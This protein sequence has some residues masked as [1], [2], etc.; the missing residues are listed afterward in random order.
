VTSTREEIHALIQ[1]RYEGCLVRPSYVLLLGDAEF[2]D[3][4]YFDTNYSSST[5]SDF[6]Y[7]NISGGL[8]D[9]LPDMGLGRIPADTLEQAEAAVSKV[10]GYEQAPPLISSF[11]A[12]A[13]IASQFQCCRSG[14]AAGTD[15]RAF[16]EESRRA[17]ITLDAAGK[18]TEEIYTR[19]GAG[20]PA[21]FFDGTLLPPD[22]ASPYPWSGSTQDIVDA[23]NSGRFLIAHR[24]HGWEEGW[25]NPQFGSD[26]V[27]ASL[28]NGNLT[29]VVYSVNCA[30][31][32]F[33]NELAGDDRGLPFGESYFCER[34]IREDDGAV[35]LIGDTRDSNTWSNTAFMRG[36]FDATWQANDP[37][38]GGGAPLRRLSDIM[39]YAKLYTIA[40]IGAP[41]TV[42]GVEAN[43]AVDT[44][45][46]Y[47]VFGDPT[48][49]MWL[50]NP[51]VLVLPGA[52]A[53]GLLTD[54]VVVKYP[55][56]G[57][58]VTAH[59]VR[60]GELVPLGRAIV[61][62]GVAQVR[63]VNGITPG[64][65]VRLSASFA[66]AIST[67]LTTVAADLSVRIDRY[68]KT[69]WPGQEIGAMLR[70]KVTNHGPAIAPGTLDSTGTPRVPP[71][72][73][74]V[75]LVLSSDNVM[76]A[77][78][79]LLPLPA[80]IAYAEDG[81]LAGGRVSRTP[82]LPGR[83]AIL[84]SASDPPGTDVGGVIPSG[85]PPGDYFLC[86]R[87]DP[88]NLVPEMKESNNA[89]CRK[90]TVVVRP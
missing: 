38:Y 2:I 82:D 9:I 39:S 27:T 72:G 21:R 75:D 33:D 89:N 7:S 17:A 61:R 8:F 50:E 11:Y 64:V 87:V 73:Y 32:F 52:A 16:I 78:L 46:L 86:A 57:A 30:S 18:Q 37:S 77:G 25:I 79:A 22:L 81:L 12:T 5:A 70:L 84:L 65:P 42:P 66:G 88:G 80:G 35:G 76:P 26:D 68:P 10:I 34:I 29:P 31:C 3:T 23:F 63:L 28:S 67:E 44:I 54:R 48:L 6:P 53:V 62:H 69:V 14:A 58:V 56:E 1:D 20:T 15:Q 19:S 74:M 4:W 36:L 24:D 45:L 55:V 13:A 51:N 43:F 40:Q 90:V 83:T 49:D 59:Q 47:H 71:A 60:D 41:S 85:T